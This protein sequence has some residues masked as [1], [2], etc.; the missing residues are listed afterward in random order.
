MTG[1]RPDYT[2][3]WDL[4]TKMRDMNPDIL[5]LPQYLIS[6]GYTTQG[7]GKIYDVRCV[8]KEL[9][10]PLIKNIRTLNNHLI[11]IPDTTDTIA[12][13]SKSQTLLDKVIAKLN[14]Y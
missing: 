7:I 14:S 8:D 6:Q 12:L 13:V 10:K 2:R 5:S 4:K 3:V 1:M 9:D 11:N